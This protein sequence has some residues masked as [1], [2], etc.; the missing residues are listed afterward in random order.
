MKS[1]SVV[2]AA[3]LLLGSTAVMADDPPKFKIFGGL[4]YVAPL[5]EEDVTIDNVEDSIEE[6]EEVGWTVGMEF[7]FNKILGLEMDYVNATND[8]EFG[9][10]TIGD[11]HMQPLS[12]TLN[13]HII[14]T[15]VV[16]LYLGPTASYF[17]WGDV[18]IDDV[19]EFKTDNEVAWGA[20]LGLDIGIGKAFAITG[21]LR[22]LNAD[23]EPEDLDK[24]GVDPLFGRLGV[25]FRFY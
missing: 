9:G 7:R 11:V 6:S 18:D 14:P 24:I 15:K 19:G 12:A 13:F 25:A 20:S 1:G 2:L 4:S 8:I 17:I 3:L 22:W 16:D 5:G 23:I 10:Q 21:G